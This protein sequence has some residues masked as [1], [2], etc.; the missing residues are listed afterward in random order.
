MAARAPAS[1]AGALVD[2]EHIGELFAAFGPVTVRRMFGG[3]GLYAD[4]V[5]F[6]L[7]ADDLIYLKTDDETS[8][9]FVAEGME[10]FSYAGRNG[11]RVMMSYWR[12]PDRLYDD[13]DELARWAREAFAAARRAAARGRGA[14]PD[15]PSKQGGRKRR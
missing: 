5:M 15:R 9:S 6:G 4:G 7:V 8:P 3:A 1:R 10:P 13:P 2:P 11:R 12:L 14:G